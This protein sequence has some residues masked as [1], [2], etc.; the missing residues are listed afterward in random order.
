VKYFW[1]LLSCVKKLAFLMF[2]IN[3]SI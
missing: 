2:I 3:F 1:H